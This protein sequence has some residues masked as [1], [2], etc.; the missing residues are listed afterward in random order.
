MFETGQI[1]RHEMPGFVR[2]YSLIWSS[3]PI[4]IRRHERASHAQRALRFPEHR[5]EEL[6]PYV[7][8]V[9]RAVERVQENCVT[10]TGEKE[11]DANATGKSQRSPT[12]ALRNNIPLSN[13]TAQDDLHS[14]GWYKSKRWSR[15]L[16]RTSVQSDRTSTG[17]KPE[18][19]TLEMMV[20]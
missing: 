14:M 13:N 19:T 4:N 17:Q 20:A 12:Y 1:W 15:S 18:R 11:C 3:D 2:I 16:V 6:A 8:A 5:T 9:E 7:R 10:A